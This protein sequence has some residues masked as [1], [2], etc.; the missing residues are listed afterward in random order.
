MLRRDRILPISEL[1]ALLG[2][3][4][5]ARID[6]NGEQ[7]LRVALVVDGFR[8]TLDVIQKS[9]AGVLAGIPAYSNTTLMGDGPI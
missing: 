7:L 4:K 5:L 2:I 9:L 8:E 3:P 1:N 6:A